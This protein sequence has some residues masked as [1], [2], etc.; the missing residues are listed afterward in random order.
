V[1]DGFLVVDRFDG[2]RQQVVE[3][4]EFTSFV[5]N[6]QGT[7]VAMQSTGGPPAISVSLVDVA[8]PNE[9]VVVVDVET[10]E[11]RTITQGAALGFFWSPNGKSLLLMTPT[12]EGLQATVWESDG[13][14]TDYQEFRPSVFLVRDMF[15]FFP[16][17]AQSMSY[18]S[19]DSTAFVFAAD[20][21]IWVQGLNSDMPDKIS[22][23]SWVA[24]S[25]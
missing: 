21:G 1:D 7:H 25:R 19:P 13:S 4:G 2:E 18:W 24:W 6:L 20:D 22:D 5:V 17:Y 3:V 16:Q 23:G 14:E 8:I 11:S 15:P 12:G 9:V 10:G